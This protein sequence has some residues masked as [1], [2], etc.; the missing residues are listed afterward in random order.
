MTTK[1]NT[2]CVQRQGGA[3]LASYTTASL[4]HSLPPRLAYTQ[5]ICLIIRVLE[6]TKNVVFSKRMYIA[7]ISHVFSGCCSSAGSCSTGGSCSCCSSSSLQ[8]LLPIIN[9]FIISII[10]IHYQLG[11]HFNKKNYSPYH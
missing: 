9:I 11:H 8:V 7:A 10:I 3:H 1:H 4:G 2:S 6:R 5:V